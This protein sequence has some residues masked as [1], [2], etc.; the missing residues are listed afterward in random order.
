VHAG[1][2][3]GKRAAA[4]AAFVHALPAEDAA[5][6]LCNAS[7]WRAGCVESGETFPDLSP[8]QKMFTMVHDRKHAG[9]T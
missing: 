3:I 9:E 4:A 6:G 5:A 1:E 8:D 7:T 2:V